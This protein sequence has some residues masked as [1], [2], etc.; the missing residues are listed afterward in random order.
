MILYRGT[1]RSI[2]QPKINPKSRF[3]C[4]GQGVYLTASKKWAEKDASSKQ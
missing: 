1:N 4:F 3:L 2:A